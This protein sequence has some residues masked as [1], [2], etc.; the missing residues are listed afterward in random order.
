MPHSYRHRNT[1]AKARNS[2]ENHR[3]SA[4][5]KTQHPLGYIS[6]CQALQEY[7]RLMMFAGCIV[8]AVSRKRQRRIKMA[9]RLITAQTK[10]PASAELLAPWNRSSEV[11]GNI[12]TLKLTREQNPLV[13]PDVFNFSLFQCISGTSGDSKLG[14]TWSG[15]IA[16]T[17]DR[18]NHSLM[19]ATFPPLQEKHHAF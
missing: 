6:K 8:L 2:C 4:N 1:E 19:L 5:Q 7:G 10:L 16:S 14:L 3:E 18:M 11:N 15:L 13:S 12:C 9:T 17:A